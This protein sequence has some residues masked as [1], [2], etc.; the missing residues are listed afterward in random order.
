M[1]GTGTPEVSDS[2]E[3][4]MVLLRTLLT[5]SDDSATVV[6]D[7]YSI[8][9]IDMSTTRRV[10]RAYRGAADAAPRGVQGGQYVA[11]VL[12]EDAVVFVI[13]MRI[14]RWRRIRSWWPV[15]TGMPRMLAELQARDAGLLGAR[16]YW[17]GR[18][19]P[20]PPALAQRRGARRLR[21]GPQLPSR[22]RLGRVQQAG[23]REGRRR[24]LPR[25]LRGAA[26]PDRDALRQHAG[27]RPGRCARRP[28]PRRTGSAH[29][30][31]RPPRLDRAG[32]RRGVS[33][34][35]LAA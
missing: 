13:G 20:G 28:T 12:T 16:S 19:L 31:P 30:R 32:V 4:R 33:A 18:T 7:T 1:V 21:P 15:F 25:D 26:G 8:L 14:N 5:G 10:P 6:L 34:A 11:E 23:R 9:E 17:S 24:H 3:M 35:R 29:R 27:V 22:P 2:S